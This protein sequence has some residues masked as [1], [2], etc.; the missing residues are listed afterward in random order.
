MKVTRKV[1]LLSL[2]CVAFVG[3]AVAQNVVNFKQLQGFMPKADLAGYTKG[4]PGGSTSSAMGMSSSEATLNYEKS[5][6]G[7]IEV[8]ISDTA[9]VPM[10]A[11][12]LSMM[13]MTEYENETENGYDK[14]I[15]VQGF[16]GTEKVDRSESKSAEISVVVAKRFMVELRCV[17]CDDIASL[18]KLVEGMDLAGLAKLAK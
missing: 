17:D 11:M 2:L 4:K 12:G 18:K 8:K 14:T 1:V 10:A 5:G 9:G 7:T 15:K 6:G 16:P 3:T 13:G